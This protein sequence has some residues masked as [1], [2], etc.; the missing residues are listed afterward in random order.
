MFEHIGIIQNRSRKSLPL[1]CSHPRFSTLLWARYVPFQNLILPSLTARASGKNFRLE[2]ILTLTTRQRLPEISD[3][4]GTVAEL[5]NENHA[6]EKEFPVY[7]DNGLKGTL[8]APSRFLDNSPEKRIRLDNGREL[9][10]PSNALEAQRDGSFYLKDAG[11][12]AGY[13]PPPEPELQQPE[14]EPPAEQPRAGSSM[15]NPMPYPG[16]SSV[17]LAE[18]LLREDCEIERVSIRRLIDAPAETRHAA[19]R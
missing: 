8:L 6:V 15:S 12:L 5:L 4:G 7:G 1:R 9:V 17:N 2:V 16:D 18:P 14:P 3:D 11:Q 10:V 13:A 19:R